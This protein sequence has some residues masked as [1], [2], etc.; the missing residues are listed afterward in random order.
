MEGERKRRTDPGCADTAGC[1]TAENS[2][3]LPC[4]AKLPHGSTYR[5]RSNAPQAPMQLAIEQL[6]D[7]LSWL[8]A[9][10]G[11]ARQQAA[12]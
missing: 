4:H 12:A 9:D 2:S 8:N 5:E 3:Y 6:A 11:N 1:R 10:D 7:I